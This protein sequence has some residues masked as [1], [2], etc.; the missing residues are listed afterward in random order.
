MQRRDR[1]CKQADFQR[2]RQGR[3][4]WAHP[5]VVLAAAPN[6]LEYSRV[7]LITGRPLGNAVRR[8]RARRLLREAA[9]QCLPLVAPGWDLVLIARA[10]LVEEKLGPVKEA[11]LQLLQRAGLVQ[12][13]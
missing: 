4:S 6:A 13:T 7:G 9:R 12:P 2:V 1:L 11:L 5:L 8:N 10:P 3:R